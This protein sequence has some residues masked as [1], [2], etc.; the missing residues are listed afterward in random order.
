MGDQSKKIARA[1]ELARQ[2]EEAKNTPTSPAH[3][4]P[5]M[6]EI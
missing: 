6:S 2:F 3:P 4:V 5:V 1:A